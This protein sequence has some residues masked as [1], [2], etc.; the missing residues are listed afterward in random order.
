M[1]CAQQLFVPLI[2]H[3]LFGVGHHIRLPGRPTHPALLWE[4]RLKFL[5][6]PGAGHPQLPAVA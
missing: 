2:L 6:G 1:K 5:C 3:R 4:G